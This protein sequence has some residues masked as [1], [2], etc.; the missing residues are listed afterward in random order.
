MRLSSIDAIRGFT[1]LLVIYSHVSYVTILHPQAPS[2]LNELF[3][4]FRMPLFFLIS[5]FFVYSSRYTPQLVRK[6]IRNRIVRQLYPT[7]VFFILCVLVYFDSNLL[8]SVFDFKKRGYWF[9]VTAV[10]MFFLVTPLFLI[11]MRYPDITSR[12]ATLLVT[13]YGVLAGAGAWLA[14]YFTPQRVDTTL[15][16]LPLAQYFPYFIGG[17]LLKINYPSLQR[18]LLNRWTAFVSLLLFAVAVAFKETPG[19]TYL[20]AVT[21][22]VFFFSLFHQLWENRAI[23]QSRIGRGLAWL[24]TMT[25]EIYLMHYFII[26][27]IRYSGGGRF[28]EPFIN[29]PW[30]FPVIMAMCVAVAMTCLGAVWLLKRLRLYG[31]LFPQLTPKTPASAPAASALPS[32]RP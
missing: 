5:G 4:I 3:V 31:L 17:M 28:I 32:P 26:Y 25:L 22:I 27:T 18:Y 1:I 16:L 15:G 13:A 12:R 11:L 7:V 30:E 21:A 20:G 24:G 8:L 10:E 9:T 2:H 6:R 29:Q 14:H 19:M 23:A